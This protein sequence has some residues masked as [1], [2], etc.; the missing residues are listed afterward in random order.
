MSAGWN[1]KLLAFYKD[2]MKKEKKTKCQKA[3][4][5]LLTKCS[6]RSD[7]SVS[8]VE[9]DQLVCSFY[10]RGLALVSLL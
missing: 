2:R 4:L 3:N 7:R 1:L 6:T 5:A 10:H 9:S 8:Y